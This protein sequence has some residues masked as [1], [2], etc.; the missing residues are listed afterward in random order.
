MGIRFHFYKLIF[1]ERNILRMF[2]EKN[3]LE[4]FYWGLSY[5]SDYEFITTENNLI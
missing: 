4:K 5:P 1:N 3:K 2:Y